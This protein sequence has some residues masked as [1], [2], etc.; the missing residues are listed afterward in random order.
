MDIKIKKASGIIEDFDS[1]KLLVSLIM[2][3]ADREHAE[4]VI[5]KVVS[6]IRPYTSTKKIFRLAHKYLRQFNRSSVLR[7]SLKNALLRLGPTGYPF[8]RYFGELL[9]HYGYHVNV[10]VILDGKCVK[11][12]VDVFAEGDH[13][14]SIVECKYRHRAENAPDV[15]TAMYFHSRF[16]DLRAAMKYKYSGKSFTGYLVT[17]TRFTTDAIQYATCSGLKLVSWRYPEKRG[18]E[19]MIEEKKLYPITVLS[20]LNSRHIRSL[21]EQKIVLMKDLAQMETE[22]LRRLLS[23]TEKRAVDLKEA[24]DQLCFC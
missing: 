13:D 14:I 5:S 17:N 24:A 23:I 7:Y 18:L 20:G 2:S 3:G 4:E 10:G 11:H 19:K 16:R 12:E 22:D 1:N 6:E 8:E 9:E 15:K 21:F